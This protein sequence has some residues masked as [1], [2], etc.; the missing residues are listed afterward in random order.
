MNNMLESK[1]VVF[2]QNYE[3]AD[4]NR[5]FWPSFVKFENGS[6]QVKYGQNL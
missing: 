1:L 4:E 3:K 6:N 2:G 5:S